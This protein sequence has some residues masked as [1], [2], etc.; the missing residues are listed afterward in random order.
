MW[1]QGK[2]LV[3]MQPSMREVVSFGE[4]WYYTHGREIAVVRTLAARVPPDV[5]RAKP[6]ASGDPGTMET[7]N[8]GE[9]T[10]A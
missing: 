3:E 10:C 7:P 4:V 2:D 8:Q 6:E 1:T 9:Q 5:R